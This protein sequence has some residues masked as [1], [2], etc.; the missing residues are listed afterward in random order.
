LQGAW[1]KAVLWDLAATPK[2]RHDGGFHELCMSE[3]ESPMSFGN[4]D[5]PHTSVSPSAFRESM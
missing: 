5:L 2:S 3:I 1:V 4:P